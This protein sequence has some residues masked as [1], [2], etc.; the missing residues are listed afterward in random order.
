MGSFN[1]AAA[2]T[3]PIWSMEL[4]TEETTV[5]SIGMLSLRNIS[6]LWRA[7]LQNVQKPSHAVMTFRPS[8]SVI[9]TV[10]VAAATPAGVGPSSCPCLSLLYPLQTG[11]LK[12]LSLLPQSQVHRCANSCIAHQTVTSGVKR[13]RSL[14]PVFSSWRIVRN[15]CRSRWGI[16]R[17]FWTLWRLVSFP[18]WIGR[19]LYLRSSKCKLIGWSRLETLGDVLIVGVMS[20]LT[21]L[22][23][24]LSPN[25]FKRSLPCNPHTGFHLVNH[26]AQHRHSLDLMPEPSVHSR[27]GWSVCRFGPM[28]NVV[29]L[30]KLCQVLLGLPFQIQT[31]SEWPV[32]VS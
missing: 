22:F 21:D 28:K 9:V 1:I 23:C 25:P 20:S 31:K 19:S 8:T 24:N 11:T 3:S 6:K 30:L 7:F 16:L 32:P 13:T 18:T 17:R 10:D 5:A 2:D 15:L 29:S 12:R 14:F 26:S 4:T 27:L